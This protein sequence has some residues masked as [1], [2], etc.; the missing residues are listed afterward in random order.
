M[1]FRYL[2]NIKE[3]LSIYELVFIQSHILQ[4]AIITFVGQ[5]CTY[6]MHILSIKLTIPLKNGD[7]YFPKDFNIYIDPHVLILRASLMDQW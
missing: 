3:I 5:K 2:R 6:F 1:F 7:I 4:D